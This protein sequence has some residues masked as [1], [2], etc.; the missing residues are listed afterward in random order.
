[1]NSHPVEVY[2]AIKALRYKASDC[3]FLGVHNW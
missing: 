1:M 2:K 3:Q